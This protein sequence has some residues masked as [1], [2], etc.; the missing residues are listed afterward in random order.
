MLKDM[1]IPASPNHPHCNTLQEMPDV[2]RSLN[3]K[4]V[5]NIKACVISQCMCYMSNCMCYKSQVLIQNCLSLTSLP[6]CPQ[7][8]TATPGGGG[9][10]IKEPAYPSGAPG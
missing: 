6:I 1:V 3:P 2:L 5:L 7:N 9:G 4:Y 10:V 8:P